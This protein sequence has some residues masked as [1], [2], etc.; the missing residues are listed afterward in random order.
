MTVAERNPKKLQEHIEDS[1]GPRIEPIGTLKFFHLFRA[2][3]S[4]PKSMI[5][6][7]I[8]EACFS[9]FLFPLMFFLEALIFIH[10]INT[11]SD[12]GKEAML[13]LL[14]LKELI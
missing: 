8:K 9:Y 5:E 12:F 7:C 1:S 13:H 11:I 4:N 3:P 2:T 14:L 10:P 6:L